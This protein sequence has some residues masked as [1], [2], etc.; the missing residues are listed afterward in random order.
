V[1][2]ASEVRKEYNI[3]KTTS[4]CDL[5]KIAMLFGGERGIKLRF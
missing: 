5:E 4:C 3:Y 2:N 1:R